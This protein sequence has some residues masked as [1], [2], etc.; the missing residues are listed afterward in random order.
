MRCR[1]H[2][3]G[4][5]FHQTLINL[6]ADY[7]LHGEISLQDFPRTIDRPL[8]A[9]RWLTVQTNGWPPGSEKLDSIL[10]FRCGKQICTFEINVLLKVKTYLATG[11]EMSFTWLTSLQNKRGVNEGYLKGTSGT[12]RNVWDC[13]GTILCGVCMFFQRLCGISLVTPP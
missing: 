9:Q 12:L 6:E 11:R 4:I 5:C 3:W 7:V 2:V 8:A 10:I 1:C 13:P